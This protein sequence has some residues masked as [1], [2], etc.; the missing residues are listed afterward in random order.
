MKTQVVGLDLNPAG[1]ETLMAGGMPVSTLPA[2]DRTTDNVGAALVTDV[3]MNDTT[4]LTPKF[5]VI[6]ATTAG[7]N[8]IV[9]AVAAKQIR[10]LQVFLVNG[11]TTTQTVRF[12]SGAGGT[13]LTGQMILAANDGFV[14][15]FSPVGWFQT[16]AG[17]LLNL[18]L[19]GGTTVDGNLV[20][21]EV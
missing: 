15:P 5:A 20:Y 9:A 1:T 11:A 3:L 16:A 8:T 12:Q 4:A 7:N 6:D 2:A 14:L 18:Q 13:A 10:V 21:V 19:V 17:A